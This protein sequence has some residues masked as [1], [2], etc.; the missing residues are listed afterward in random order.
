M[1]YGFFMVNF[2]VLMLDDEFQKKPIY[3]WT[4]TPMLGFCF[5]FIVN[6]ILSEVI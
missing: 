1:I 6:Q 3:K 5:T 2:L 4:H